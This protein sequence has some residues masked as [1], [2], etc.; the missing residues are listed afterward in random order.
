MLALKIA[1]KDTPGLASASQLVDRTS[2]PVIDVNDVSTAP[3]QGRKLYITRFVQRVPAER[4]RDVKFSRVKR[5]RKKTRKKGQ[6][7]KKKR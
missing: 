5:D 3:S 1:W 2:S 4:T 7:S 6:V